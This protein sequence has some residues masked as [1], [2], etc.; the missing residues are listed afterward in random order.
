MD[1]AASAVARLEQH[2]ARMAIIIRID[3]D[4]PYGRQPLLRHVLSRVG[5]DLYFPRVRGLGYLRELDMILRTLNRLG[6]R[7]DVFF[8][9]C[10]FPSSSIIQSI[11]AGGHV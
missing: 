2:C 11:R 7:A 9:R 1:A 6:G 10:T 5:S 4:R 3:V 8:R